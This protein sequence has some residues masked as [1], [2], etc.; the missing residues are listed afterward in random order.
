MNAKVETQD[1]RLDTVK[2]GFAI[3][4]L[5][6]AI[7]GF[8]YYSE[9]STLLRVLG[10]LAAAGV[11]VFVALQTEI[12]RRFWGFIQESRAEVRKVVWPTRQETVQTTL[13]VIVMVILVGILLWLLDMF[14]VWAV[15][16]LTGQG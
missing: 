16:L 2:L 9:H 5:L 15:R 11:A 8:Y 10:L 4:I 3:A 12:G 6:A 7:F 14:L 1:S 13:I